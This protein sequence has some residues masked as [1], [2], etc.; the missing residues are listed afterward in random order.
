M[1]HV[2]ASEQPQDNAMVIEARSN[3][4]MSLEGLTAVFA[5]LCGVTLLVTAWPVFMGLWPILLAA[6][7]HLALVGWCFRA[8]WRGNWAREK[9]LIHDDALVVEQYR[10]GRQSRSEWPAAWTRVHLEPGRLG[11]VRVVIACQGRRQEIGS[12]LPVSERE[13]LAI[14]LKDM[15]NGCS[16]WDE[17]QT[18]RISRG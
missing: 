18:I 7:L 9:L 3:L 14:A 6:L 5:G 15:L 4:S 2:T 8:A 11:D 17:P 12:F 13:E 10:L 16:A 1:L